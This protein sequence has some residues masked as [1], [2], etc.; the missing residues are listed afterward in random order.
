MTYKVLTDDTQKAIHRSVL[1][2]IGESTPF[3]PKTID[4]SQ[5]LPVLTGRDRVDDDN[6]TPLPTIKVEDLVGRTF[7]MGRQEDGQRYRAKIVEAITEHEDGLHKEDVR[8]KFRCTVNDEEFEEIVS[9]NE[10]LDH[11]SKDET[12]EGMWRFK[13]ITAHQGP[14]SQSDSAYRGSRY[15]VLVNWETGESTFEPLS[16]IA[17][18]DPVTCAVYAKE[19]GLLEEDGWK[20]F[21]KLA[22]RQTRL[23]RMAKQARLRSLRTTPVYKFGYLVPRNH[24][25][26]VEIDTKNGNRRWQ[27]AEHNEIFQLDEYHTFFDKGKYGIPQLVTRRSDATWCMM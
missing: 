21:K 16:I 24:E 26:A 22:R 17:A 6:M 4:D 13:S 12:E 8:I 1:R 15:N 19:N 27:E 3:L 9:Y 10:L 2:P 20:Q 23:V 25:Q 11:I 7:L 18:D 14:L 5:T